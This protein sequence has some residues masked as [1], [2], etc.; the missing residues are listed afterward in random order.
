MSDDSMLEKAKG[1]AKE[2]AGKATG[3]DE[4][5]KEGQAQQKKAHKQEEADRLAEKAEH[6]RRQ[7][8]GHAADEKRH[9][10]T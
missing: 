1:T 5:A 3:S 9:Q 7:A 10:G 4:M 6:K 8:A 2:V